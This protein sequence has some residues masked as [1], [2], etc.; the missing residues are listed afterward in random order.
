MKEVGLILLVSICIVRLVTYRRWI[1]EIHR[2]L[3]YIR[4]NESNLLLRDMSYIPCIKGLSNE[5]N[6]LIKEYT[7]KNVAQL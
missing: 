3:V 4:K 7:S 5:I 2:H 6:E 1:K